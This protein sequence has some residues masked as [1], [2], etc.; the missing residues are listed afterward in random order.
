MEKNSPNRYGFTLVEL[1]VVIAIIGILVALL[2]PAVQKAR[3]AARRIQCANTEKQVGLA[4]LN[5]ESAKRAFPPGNIMKGAINS[6]NASFS[7]WTIEL[8]PYIEDAAVRSLYDSNIDVMDPKFKVFRETPI[9]VYTCPSDFASTLAVPHS[10]PA[11]NTQIQFRTS[12]YRG[13]AG[14]TGD[15]R[16]TWYLGEDIGNAMNPVE[17]RGPLTAVVDRRVNFNPNN[18]AGKTLSKLRPC[19]IRDIKDGTTK[20]MLIGES[21]NLLDRR[22][23]FWAYASW[24]NYILSQGNE[25]PSIFSGNYDTN[26]TKVDGGCRQTGAHP[27]TCMS[28]WYSGHQGGMNIC[29]CDGSVRFM[30]FEVD[31]AAFAALTSIAG[32]EVAKLE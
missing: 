28:A 31:L 8:L 5:Y 2:L 17:F 13:N 10:G 27:R 25:F 30:P 1:L 32:G 24:G 23:T 4:L 18:Q 16:G 7:G 19:K 20:T 3:E 6:V 11:K 22:R 14:R 12:S 9:Q 21:T 26:L 29:L 15:G